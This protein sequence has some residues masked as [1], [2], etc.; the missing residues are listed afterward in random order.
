M[1][2]H[3]WLLLATIVTE[4]LVIRKW[5]RAVFTQPFPLHIKW[6]LSIGVSLLVLY[7]VTKASIHHLY[8]MFMTS[9]TIANFTVFTPSPFSSVFHKH[10]GTFA[11]R[12]RK[13][14]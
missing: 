7:P 6:G 10:D 5:G 1:G 9:A 14:V 11:K 2:A 3:A 4:L 13:V 8:W 12:E